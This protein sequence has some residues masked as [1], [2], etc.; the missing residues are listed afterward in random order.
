MPSKAVRFLMLLVLVLSVGCV[1]SGLPVGGSAAGGLG[2]NVG[3]RIGGAVRQ[4]FVQDGPSRPTVASA[5]YSHRTPS[6]SRKP[7]AKIKKPVSVAERPAM[8]H[9]TEPGTQE[10]QRTNPVIK[11]KK[12]DAASTWCPLENVW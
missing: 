3:Y 5:N 11:T 8:E 10:V 2:Y 1:S 9:R 6:P 4:L 12:S 7:V